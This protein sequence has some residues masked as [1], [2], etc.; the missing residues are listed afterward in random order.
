MDTLKVKAIF[1]NLAKCFAAKS[2]IPHESQFNG[3]AL[4]NKFE[5][6]F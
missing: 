5:N 6:S 1:D 3:A 2:E 4:N